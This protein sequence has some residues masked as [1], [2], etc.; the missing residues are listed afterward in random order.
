M[1]VAL[2]V[3]ETVSWRLD[4]ACR[5]S[6]TLAPSSLRLAAIDI[7]PLIMPILVS[8]SKSKHV[9][10][11]CFAVPT[12]SWV[13][14]R[15]SYR[16][17]APRRRRRSC[18]TPP[19]CGQTQM[20]DVGGVPPGLLAPLPGETKNSVHAIRCLLFARCSAQ[21]NMPSIATN[22]NNNNKTNTAQTSS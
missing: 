15:N 10:F 12:A 14:L 16:Y 5:R 4:R 1:I 18:R 17:P 9:S 11:I 2:R 21:Y 20:G 6:A 8:E 13:V 7:Q 22:N 3:T 19:G